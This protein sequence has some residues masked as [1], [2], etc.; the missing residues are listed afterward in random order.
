MSGDGEAAPAR[1]LLV[2]ADSDS[3][4]KWG[5][6]LA[7]RVAGAWASEVVLLASPVLPSARQLDAALAGSGFA[8]AEVRTLELDALLAR[9]AADPPDAVLLALRGPL[10]R[11]VAGRIAGLP[12][13][14][15][16]VSGF[17]GLTI[18]AEPKAIVYRELV[19]LVVLHSRRE[20]REFAAN[21]RALGVAMRFGLATLPFLAAVPPSA[22][23]GPERNELL[24]A[25]QAKV[26]AGFEERVRLLGMLAR[27]A[28]AHPD[29]HVVLKVRA[30]PGEAQTH[31]EEFDLG[32]LLADPPPELLALTGGGLPPNLVVRDGPMSGHLESAAALVTVSSTAVLEAIAV[33]VPVLL[34]EDFGIGPKQINTVFEGSGLFGDAAELAAGRW[35]QP[36]AGWLGDNYF[37]GEEHD[38]WEDE[39]DRLVAARERGPLPVP[40]RRHNL[41]GGALRRAYERKRMLGDYDRTPAG[42]AA[43]V[44][45]LPARWL[46]RRARRLRAA[47]TRS[48][49]Y[50]PRGA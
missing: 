1:R 44:V 47:V 49:P 6:A 7:G 50:A 10:V 30:R 14:P 46:L 39:L 34:L 24:F 15:V 27:A 20:L 4:A 28:R 31:A 13:R 21:A 26:P 8:P 32:E 48:A 23:V 35:R 43:M 33:G 11:V 19:D 25:V 29:H 45:A 37:H 12:N 17:P 9:L 18:P 5:A 3:Y 36:D 38:D 41:V 16:L 22:W 40:R 42:A 2:V